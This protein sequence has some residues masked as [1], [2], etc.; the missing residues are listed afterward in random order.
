MSGL[1]A[2]LR[3]GRRR[4][5]PPACSARDSS[6]CPWLQPRWG[7]SSASSTTS[8]WCC[9]GKAPSAPRPATA[10]PSMAV[11]GY[12]VSL[13]L[14]KLDA[15]GDQRSTRLLIWWSFRLTRWPGSSTSGCEKSC[16][17]RGRLDLLSMHLLLKHFSSS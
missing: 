1:H 13:S 8:C 6:G 15:I 3:A 5:L 4:W 17:D 14:H 7:R 11:A 2:C 9:S 16:G 12:I 10:A